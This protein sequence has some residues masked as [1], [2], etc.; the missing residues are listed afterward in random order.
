MFPT[1]PYW[2]WGQDAGPGTEAL[3]DLTGRRVGDL[4]AGAARHAAH[5]AVHHQPA[6][7]MAIDASPAQYARAT[8]L[9]AHLAPCLRIVQS[10]SAVHRC[11][12]DS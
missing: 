8:D 9:Y 6:R 7:V 5:L 10:D 2:T 12:A 11:A 1:P 4:G 3:G